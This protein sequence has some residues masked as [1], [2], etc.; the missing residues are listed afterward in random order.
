MDIM[1]AKFSSYGFLKNLRF[2]EPFF[3]LFFLDKGLNYTMIGLLITVREISSNI[4]EIPSGILADYFSK[5]TCMLFS[6][7]SYIVSFLIIGLINNTIYYFIAMILYGFGEAFRSG[8]HKSII[9][10]W[11]EKN[12]ILD[13]KH[14]YYGY[15][16]SWSLKGSAISA[17]L[18]ALIVIYFH[19]YHNIFL[20][21]IIP[22]ILCFLL[23]STY[24]S[25][26]HTNKTTV[27]K[28]M[29][30]LFS[31]AVSAK[32]RK[33]ILNTSF[34]ESIF[35]CTKDF[36]QPLLMLSVS[37]LCTASN[38]HTIT[39]LIIG[40]FYSIIFLVSS[41]V[42][43]NSYRIIKSIRS[44]STQ[45]LNLSFFLLPLILICGAFSFHTKGYLSLF[46]LLLLFLILFS[47]FNLRKPLMVAYFTDKTD[48]SH[49]AA[50]L[51]VNSQSVS[52]L[53]IIFSPI[54]GKAADLFGPANALLAVG[55][56]IIPFV[57]FLRLKD[58][59]C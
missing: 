22:Y 33:I 21:S 56:F 18:A 36:L 10:D 40:V 24:P 5:K 42:S 17:L 55:I 32:M 8:T 19:G 53:T 35:K 50:I 38:K 14:E 26:T 28:H 27:K 23:L 29:M 39:A 51:S 16:R 4:L 25:I 54:I 31:H 2:F 49:R 52:F 57:F 30:S 6:F 15:T 13:K 43:K 3:V 7:G 44:G 9:M 41:S 12:R 37:T 58:T 11:L 1:L 45:A 34:F 47:L 59:G 20:L 48:K 46:M